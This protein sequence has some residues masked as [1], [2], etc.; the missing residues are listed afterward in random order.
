MHHEFAGGERGDNRGTQCP[1]ESAVGL[2][3]NSAFLFV[4]LGLLRLNITINPQVVFIL[5]NPLFLN[6]TSL[7]NACSTA[8]TSAKL[9]IHR[10]LGRQLNQWI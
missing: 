9:A 1:E 10:P 4:F 2:I 8:L 6:I 7:R 5:G 3:S